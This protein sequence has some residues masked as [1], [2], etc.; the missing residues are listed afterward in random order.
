MRREDGQLSPASIDI[1]TPFSLRDDSAGFQPDVVLW[2]GGEYTVMS[3]AP[4]RHFGEGFTKAK[5]VSTV[6]ADPPA[7]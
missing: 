1:A 4:Y 2:R 7:P 6:A 3:S 5:A